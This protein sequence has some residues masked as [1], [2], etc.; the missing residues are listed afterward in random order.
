M[1]REL[2]QHPTLDAG[3]CNKI[4]LPLASVFEDMSFELVILVI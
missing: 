2:K 4:V 1:N 3:R